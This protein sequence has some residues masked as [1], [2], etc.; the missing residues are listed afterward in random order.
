MS[1]DRRLAAPDEARVRAIGLALL[2]ETR[3]GESPLPAFLERVVADDPFRLQLFRLVDVLPALRDDAEVVR[4][5]GEY[6]GGSEATLARVTRLGLGLARAGWV[7][8]KAVAAAVR[9]I[10]RRLARRFIAGSTPEEAVRAAR[11]QWEAG[12]AFTLDV[13]G[14]ACLAEEEAEHYRRTY[15]RLLEALG[16]EVAA[17]PAAPILDT[18]PWGRL[19]RVNLS[20]KLSALHP[21]LDPIDPVGARRVIADRLGPLLRL[22]RAVGGHVQVDMEER[23][24]KDLTLDVFMALCGEDEFRGL[25][26]VG[27]VLQ[28]YLRDA[29]ADAER[30]V[31]WARGRGTPVT[32]R[33]VKGAYWD[34]EAAHAGLLGW[35]VPVHLDKAETDAAFERLTRYFLAH[36]GV[37]DLALGSH[38]VRS[39]AHALAA[40]EAAS[41]PP[42]TLE[43]QLLYGM[44]DPLV[45]ALVRRGER[46]RVYMPFGDLVVGMAYLVR[47]LLENT[48]NTSFLRR[49]FALEE[50]AAALLARPAGDG[51]PADAP[52]RPPAGFRNEPHAD[53]SLA[54]AREGLAAALST[55]RARLGADHPV[56]VD[57]EPVATADWLVSTN[58]GRPAEVI[59]RAGAASAADVDR[60]VDAA[61]R[62]FPGWRDLGP[63]GRSAVLA[64]V[65]D[66]LRAGRAELAAL[67]VL[68]GG[69]P[70]RE[71]D[72]D[73]AEA[74]DFIEYYRRQAEALG[75]PLSLGE[76]PGEVNR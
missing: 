11:T 52:G 7:G 10:V 14:E 3:G 61:R 22:A 5:L 44:A 19:P 57:G 25:R 72:A 16:P 33:L 62:A 41:L 8:E 48:S 32:V 49:T 74:V 23:R 37:V 73:V 55:V 38:N 50:P 34:H 51:A 40:R 42:G 56:L 35:P 29:E 68:E 60:A 17:W 70:W 20:V 66:R 2:G 24:L 63:A 76:R 18:A 36:A 28:A 26:E 46:V 65:A 45:R 9:Q 67:M 71:A 27:V 43:L 4:H 12:A 47:R 75:A 1:G 31:A 58:P 54:P 39:I 13:L 69:K 15:A 53:F 21:Y 59:G 30:L 64:R 6:L